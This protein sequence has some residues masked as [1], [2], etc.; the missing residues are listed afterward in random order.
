MTTCCFSFNGDS[1]IFHSREWH[2]IERRYPLVGSELKTLR[3]NIE[4]SAQVAMGIVMWG[5]AL[6]AT[7]PVTPE[8]Q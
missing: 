7:H 6:R 3:A 4:T 5:E 1:M 8:S 2:M